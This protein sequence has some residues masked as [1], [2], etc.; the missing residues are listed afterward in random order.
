MLR[1]ETSRL[2]LK[3]NK[4]SCILVVAKGTGLTTYKQE[5]LR[6]VDVFQLWTA[7]AFLKSC[8]T[9]EKGYGEYPLETRPLDEFVCSST[10]KEVD[11]YKNWEKQGFPT[12]YSGYKL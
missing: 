4:F 8:S 11:L 7:T 5:H 2:A 3:I 6:N 1:Q 9:Y 12:N 10:S